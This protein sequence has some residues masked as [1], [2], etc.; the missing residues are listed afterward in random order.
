MTKTR[1]KKATKRTAIARSASAKKGDNV[2]GISDAAVKEKTGKTWGQWCKLLDK[3]GAKKMSHKDIALLVS[4]KH[5]VGPWWSQMVTVGYEQARGL[6]KK[7]ETSRG[8]QAS[9][10]KTV[11]APLAVL[12][13]AWEDAK[14]RARW[15]GRPAFTMRKKT[16]N[17]SM[18]IAWADETSVEVN[19]YA[20][21]EGKSH[22]AVQHSKLKGEP[23]VL[24]AKK[25]WAGALDTLKERLEE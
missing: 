25:F 11:N 22:V 3:D 18:R 12:Y 10:S 15:L 20:K 2:A 16:A 1:R 6:R 17:K 19:F 13:D 8:W 9:A 14:L 4:D 24:K 7:H 5:G 23:E 21:G